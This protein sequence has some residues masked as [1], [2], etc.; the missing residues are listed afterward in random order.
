MQIFQFV[1]IL[2]GVLGVIGL[3]VQL[4]FSQEQ[5]QI[6]LAVLKHIHNLVVVGVHHRA[7]HLLD[8]FLYGYV[9]NGENVLRENKQERV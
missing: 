2:V 8:V 6:V 5:G 7:H 4:Q 1:V 9:V 3:L